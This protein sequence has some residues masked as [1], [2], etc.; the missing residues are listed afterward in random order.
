MTPELFEFVSSNGKF[1][2]RV[3]VHQFFPS[4]CP[5]PRAVAVARKYESAEILNLVTLPSLG[6]TGGQLHT[7]VPA[8]S[9]PNTNYL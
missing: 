1:W 9:C 3:K 4:L 7:C 2:W 8:L 6:S 5:G